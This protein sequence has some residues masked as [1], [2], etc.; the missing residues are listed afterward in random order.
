MAIYTM[1]A[2]SKTVRVREV[3]KTQRSKG[4]VSN[5][6][7]MG[8]SVLPDINALALVPNGPWARAFISGRAL[9]P[10]AKY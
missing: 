6:H 2:L 5:L 9:V 7:T 4:M 3:F 8:T 10:I 1:P